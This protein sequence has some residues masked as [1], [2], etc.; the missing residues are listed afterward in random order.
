MERAGQLDLWTSLRILS[1][2][3]GGGLAICTVLGSW[4]S[5][6]RAARVVLALRLLEELRLY[7]LDLLGVSLVR[8]SSRIRHRP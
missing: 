4:R 7:L 1:A 3:L 5:R 6:K 8:R 2:G